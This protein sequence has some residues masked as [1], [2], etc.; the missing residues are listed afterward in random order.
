MVRNQV[1]VLKGPKV[2]NVQKSCSDPHIFLVESIC[3]VISFML[4]VAWCSKK[5]SILFICCPPELHVLISLWLLE[6][7]HFISNLI[8]VWKFKSQK[9]TPTIEKSSKIPFSTKLQ[10]L[11]NFFW[12]LQPGETS[13]STEFTLRPPALR[14]SL[15]QS[16]RR[17]AEEV[18][19][20]R[21]VVGP[22]RP[23]DGVG[24]SRLRAL[25]P[26]VAP[27]TLKGEKGYFQGEKGRFW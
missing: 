15:V 3:A 20:G 12:H 13:N 2:Y 27:Q 7:I 22:G 18:A 14:I 11:E 5:K 21:D 4:C 10:N 6:Q 1:Q 9:Y 19:Q 26:G 23:V 25:P 24:A 16:L 17:H 8:V